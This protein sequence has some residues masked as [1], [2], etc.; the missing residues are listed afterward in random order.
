[1]SS[2][3]SYALGEPVS[4]KIIVALDV[5]DMR[6]WKLWNEESAGDRWSVT[7]AIVRVMLRGGRYRDCNAHVDERYLEIVL[8]CKLSRL[9]S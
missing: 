5:T 2:F 6:K 8:L 1:M 9:K 7:S 4:T 3:P